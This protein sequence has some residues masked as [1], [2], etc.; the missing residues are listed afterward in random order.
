MILQCYRALEIAKAMSHLHNG[1]CKHFSFI[2]QKRKIL[3]IGT[4]NYCKS[5]P[6]TLQ[7]DYHDNAK[8]HSELDAVISLGRKSCKNLILVNIRLDNN[9]NLAYSKPCNGCSGLIRQ[10]QFKKVYYSVNGKF[11]I[12]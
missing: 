2:F 12:L 4:N 1:R 3:T 11:K 8:L 6:R 5:H 7:F 9:G 10:L